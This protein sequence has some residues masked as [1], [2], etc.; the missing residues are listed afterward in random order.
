MYVVDDVYAADGSANLM[1]N[2]LWNQVNNIHV[3]DI[4]AEV[5]SIKRTFE[6]IWNYNSR[7]NNSY[8]DNYGKARRYR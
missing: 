1:Y 8:Y 6:K 5:Q 7:E 4:P 3:Y 2:G